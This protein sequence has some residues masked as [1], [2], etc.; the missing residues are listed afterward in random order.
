MH[1]SENESAEWYQDTLPYSG[2]SRIIRCR[3]GGASTI[4]AMTLPTNSSHAPQYM[5][6]LSSG[7]N[8]GPKPAAMRTAPPWIHLARYLLEEAVADRLPSIHRR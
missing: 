3:C 8:G 1:E 5:N 7:A 4:A 6:S 2:S